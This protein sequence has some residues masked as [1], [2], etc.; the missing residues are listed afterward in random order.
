M[1]VIHIGF[2]KKARQ[3]RGILTSLKVGR[4]DNRDITLT[5]RFTK[6]SIEPV[7]QVA[8]R[9]IQIFTRPGPR[10]GGAP[11]TGRAKLQVLQWEVDG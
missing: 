6:G 8:C 7:R 3:A 2:H 10:V 11:H 1:P 5:P 4:R 9:R